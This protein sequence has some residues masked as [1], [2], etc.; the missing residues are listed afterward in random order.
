M[1]AAL[2]I[3]LI[4]GFAGANLWLIVRLYKNTYRASATLS[5]LQYGLLIT[6]HLAEQP[7][8][9]NKLI[10]QSESDQFVQVADSLQ[11]L[12]DRLEYITVTDN[13]IVIYH[14]QSGS[15]TGKPAL[16]THR[17]DRDDSGLSTD[18]DRVIIGRKKLLVGSTIVPVITFTRK[19]RLDNGHERELQLALKKDIVAREHAGAS[20]AISTMFITAMI[21]IGGS[22]GICLLVVIGLVH[23][24]MKWQ[25]QRRQNEHLAFAGA[26]A[27]TVIHD[28]WNPMSAMRLDAQLLRNEAE[29]GVESRKGRVVEL[30]ERITK[31]IDRIDDL[32]KEFLLLSRPDS[33]DRV[34]F[35]INTCVL[36]CLELLKLR[37]EKAG[38][39]VK[40]S[41]SEVPL[42]VIGF[43]VQ[44]KR[45]LI[46]ILNN[47]EQFSSAGSTV[48]VKTLIQGKDA[49]VEVTDEGPGISHAD[50]K[51]IFAMFFSRRSG[52]IGIGLA[53]AKTAVENCGGTIHAGK[54]QKGKGSCFMIRIPMAVL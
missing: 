18:M 33:T 21:T 42:T 32:L 13:G 22:F 37:F 26:M 43:Q 10:D 30:A 38:I 16:A 49:V 15:L 45:A 24:E 47:A 2:F 54:N 34:C 29:K 4:A 36:D 40:R 12:E 6:R 19:I 39:Q 17:K 48:T 5:V 46:N 31:T 41:L 25:I 27:N 3:L 35:D 9:T 1:L 7:L 11:R 44:F 50:R 51:N 53:L 52:G 20:S 8:V 23:R 14:K 28:F